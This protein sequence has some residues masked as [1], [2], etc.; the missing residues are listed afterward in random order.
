MKRVQ[1][2]FTLIE[3]MIVV[4]IIAILAAIAIPAYQ[5]YI[6]ESKVTKCQAHF[7]EAVSVAKSFQAKI[8]AQRT[9]QGPVVFAANPP[10]PNGIASAQDWIDIV[11]NPDARSDPEGSGPAYVAG[12]AN[13]PTCSIGVAVNATPL[14]ANAVDVTFTLG[15]MYDPAGDNTGFDPNPT[16]VNG[17]PFEVIVQQDSSIIK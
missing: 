12:A 11:I 6:N 1:Q 13:A 10:L 16:P 7:E 4:A 15:A 9:R 8:L 14:I 17:N 5:Q 3:L 2:G